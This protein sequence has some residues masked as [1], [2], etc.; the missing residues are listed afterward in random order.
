VT[1]D[2]PGPP[3]KTP[4]TATFE[5]EFTDPAGNDY[6]LVLD[7]VVKPPFPGY[8]TEGGVMIDSTHHGDTGT[9]TPLMPEVETLAAFW[10]VGELFVNGELV[11]PAQVF[12][13]MTTEVV[14]NTD[15][16][17]VHEEDLPLPPSERHVRGQEHHTHLM[18]LPVTP[19]PGEGPTFEPVKTAFE[20]PNGKP[21]PFL[22]I[23]FEQDTVDAG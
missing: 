14:R 7:H 15:Y 19:V 16:E 18:V 2:P 3:G 22:H 5:A 9:G 17:L 10:G 12:H 20:L 1:A 6:R 11:Q 8:E 23:M 13:V 4:D 21:Q